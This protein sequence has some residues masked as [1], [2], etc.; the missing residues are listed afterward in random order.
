MS[1]ELSTIRLTSHPAEST[2]LLPLSK[3]SRRRQK[4]CCA[5]DASSCGIFQIRRWVVRNPTWLLRPALVGCFHFVFCYFVFSAWPALSAIFFFSSFS[6]RRVLVL[7]I[8]LTLPSMYIQHNN[9]CPRRCP[10]ETNTSTSYE[11]MGREPVSQGKTSINRG[12]KFDRSTLKTIN[13]SNLSSNRA[14]AKENYQNVFVRQ[15]V[16]AA[17]PA[18]RS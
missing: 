4:Y 17:S 5:G 13:N 16:Q 12:C 10:L 8:G 14:S 1:A 18:I 3:T 7:H 9:Q 15:G 6:C 11:Q 2:I